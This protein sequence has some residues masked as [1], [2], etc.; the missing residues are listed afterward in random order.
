MLQTS[1]SDLN[2]CVCYSWK[3]VNIKTNRCRISLKFEEMDNVFDI[4]S[5]LDRLRVCWMLG[6][7]LYRR[8]ISW[9]K[10]F[11]QSNP[12][13]AENVWW[14][15]SRQ[16]LN[17]LCMTIPNVHFS[18]MVWSQTRVCPDGL[19]RLCQRLRHEGQLVGGYRRN[20]EQH[21]Y[22]PSQ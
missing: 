17:I 22:R 15:P 14:N 10:Q 3:D 8:L 5:F 6:L 2:I 20:G 13:I 19:L 18:T 16:I 4:T 1:F 9:A 7:N 11:K 21:C 12:E